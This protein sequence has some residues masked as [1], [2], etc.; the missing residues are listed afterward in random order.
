MHVVWIEW[1]LRKLKIEISLKLYSGY[2][3]TR[4]SVIHCIFG[5]KQQLLQ[6][7]GHTWFHLQVLRRP[8]RKGNKQKNSKWKYTNMSP[9]GI[10]PAT[11]SF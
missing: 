9:P 6:V 5:L 8:A 11:L 7:N 4:H 1:S 2:K 10:E 3:Y